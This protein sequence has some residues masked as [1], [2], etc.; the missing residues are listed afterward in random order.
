MTALDGLLQGIVDDPQAEDCQ[1]VLSNH[2]LGK[3]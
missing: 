2:L 3:E 1:L